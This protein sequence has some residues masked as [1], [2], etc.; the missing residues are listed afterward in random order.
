VVGVGSPSAVFNFEKVSIFRPPKH[1]LVHVLTS[2]IAFARNPALTNIAASG[3]RIS[4]VNGAKE[5][6][7]IARWR[8]IAEV[9]KVEGNDVTGSPLLVRIW[10]DIF[11]WLI[12]TAPNGVDHFITLIVFHV[13][14][15][16]DTPP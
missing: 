5:N 11:G 12:S 9:P 10:R 3:C 16:H 4:M 8:L 7:P 6:I 1:G 2:H 14:L 13:A 15:A